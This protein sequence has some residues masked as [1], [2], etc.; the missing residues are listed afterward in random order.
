MHN[1]ANLFQCLESRKAVAKNEA[2]ETVC[3]KILGTLDSW[4]V[5]VLEVVSQIAT[6]RHSETRNEDLITL[7]TL[8]GNSSHL[9][10][11]LERLPEGEWGTLESS[12]GVGFILLE[13]LARTIRFL[14][15]DMGEHPDRYRLWA[16]EQPALPMMVFRNV[17]AYQRRF[18]NIAKVLDLGQCCPINSSKWANYDLSKPVNRLVFDTMMEFHRVLMYL[19]GSK[20][21][22]HKTILLKRA[23]VPETQ[24]KWFLIAQQL[25]P[26]TKKTAYKWAY[27]VVIPYLEVEYPNWGDVSVLKP[28]LKAKGGKS[29]AKEVIAER[30]EGLARFDL[31]EKSAPSMWP[32]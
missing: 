11:L 9:P 10:E 15:R 28:Y 17:R 2:I 12:D 3:Q 23:K 4:F 29:K 21:E 1:V 20:A 26:L 7:L 5:E 31:P 14:E 18:E 19:R 8:I 16:R 25:P 32:S 30:L 13:N 22:Q 24:V 27:D 6:V